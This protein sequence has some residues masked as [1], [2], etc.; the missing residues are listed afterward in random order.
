MKNIVDWISRPPKV[1]EDK[2]T[3]VIGA[4][5][6][7]SGTL[8]GYTHLN[9]ILLSLGMNVLN[10]P[11]LLV[12]KIDKQLEP[13]GKIISEELSKLFDNSVNQLIKK[14]NN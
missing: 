6:G 1:I 12:A 14:L 4:T 2:Y 8:L 3:L 13:K 9:H 11:R 5:P 7:L 10:Q